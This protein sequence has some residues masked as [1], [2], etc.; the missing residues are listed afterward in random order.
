MLINRV[1]PVLLIS[2]KRLV[3]TTRFKNHR[4]VGDPI[5]TI[6]IFNE[7]EV[8]ELIILDIE[9]SK[10]KRKPDFRYIEKLAGECFMP[11]TYGGGITNLSDAKKIFS[12]GVEK[13]SLNTVLFH[14]LNL[15]IEL[16]NYFGS[17]AIV[18]SID[19]KRS[20]LGKYVIYNSAINKTTNLDINLILE[21][22]INNGIGEILLNSVDR[23]GT[24]LGMD[25]NLIK[26]INLICNIPLISVGGVGSLS[27]ISDAIK[28]GSDAVGVGSFFVF[29]GPHKA[30]L[31][32]YPKYQDLKKLLESK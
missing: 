20:F 4:Y 32:T 22:L 11:L 10:Q 8:D 18:A 15:V 27:D 26:K 16:S 23:D 29:Y 31:I 17:Q 13:I 3:K 7:K 28:K 1:I 2:N 9:A 19:I 25:I 30:V 5:N 24:Q 21:K 14:D 12:L 6:K